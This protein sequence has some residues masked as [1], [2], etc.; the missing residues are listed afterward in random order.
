MVPHLK[1]EEI[2]SDLLDGSPAFVT[3]VAD[4]RRGERLIMLYTSPHI[5]PAQL[6]ERLNAAELPQLWI[7]KRENF[8]LVD[9][10]PLLGS[11]KV[12]LAKARALA[13]EKVNAALHSAAA[14]GAMSLDA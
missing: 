13:I 11:G 1:I 10:I 14:A 12:D 9:A 5:T 6:I 2:V 3:G 8:Y 7:P 4:E